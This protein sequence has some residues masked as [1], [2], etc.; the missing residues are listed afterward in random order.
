MPDFASYSIKIEVGRT[1]VNSE[2]GRLG[3]RV[4]FST[5][6]GVACATERGDKTMVIP[7]R[8]HSRFGSNRELAEEGRHGPPSDAGLF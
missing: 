7:T 2:A 5:I 1:L 4:A 3:G 6:G 8:P